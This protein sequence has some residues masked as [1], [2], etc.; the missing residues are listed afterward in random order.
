L[1]SVR[2]QLKEVAALHRIPAGQHKQRVAALADLVNELSA[3]L[4]R[5]FQRVTPLDG[6]RAAMQASQVASACGFPNCYVRIL[7][8][9]RTLHSLLPKL[10]NNGAADHRTSAPTWIKSKSEADRL[11]MT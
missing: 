1:N 3:F 10:V 9:I 8:K 2:D 5:E 4:G 7:L 11:A 6:F